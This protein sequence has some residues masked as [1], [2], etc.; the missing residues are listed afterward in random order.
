MRNVVK[1]FPGVRALDGVDLTLNRGEVLALLGENG[2]GKSTL[3]KILGGAHRPDSGELRIDGQRVQINSP[4]D[5]INAGIGIIY[6]EF[7]LVPALSAWE[8]IFLGRE[9]TTAGFIHRHTERQCAVELFERIG[10]DVPIDT[11]CGVSFT[12]IG[13]CCLMTDSVESWSSLARASV[14]T[15]SVNIPES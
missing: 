15:C 12:A 3:I 6:Q 11:P 5:A 7:N 10:V 4:A 8:N 1:T 14:V 9:T 2:A 13:E